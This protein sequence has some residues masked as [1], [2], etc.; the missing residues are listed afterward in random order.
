MLLIAGLLLILSGS[1]YNGYG[2]FFLFLP[3]L[4]FLFLSLILIYSLSSDYSFPSDILLRL[5]FVIFPPLL[6]WGYYSGEMGIASYISAMTASMSFASPSLSSY[7]STA[8][9]LG[10]KNTSASVNI[11][12][13]WSS[14]PNFVAVF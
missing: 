14:S 7:F 6:F 1:S 8:S 12:A 5:L 13:S 9:P 10:P 11:S 4:S 2:Y 3:P